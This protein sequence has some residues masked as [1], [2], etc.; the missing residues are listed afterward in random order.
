MRF[1]YL[2]FLV[3]G[4]LLGL[5]AAG[6]IVVRIVNGSTNVLFP[7]LGLV[8]SVDLIIAVLVVLAAVAFSLARLFG[9]FRARGVIR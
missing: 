6:V 1:G 9:A 4:V 5:L 8:I 2:F 7:G 3:I